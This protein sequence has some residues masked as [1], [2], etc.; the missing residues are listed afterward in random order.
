MIVNLNR[1]KSFMI[2]NPMYGI[3]FKWLMACK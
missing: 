2:A 3:V 1:L